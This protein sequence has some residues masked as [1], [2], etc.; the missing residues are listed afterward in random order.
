VSTHDELE[1]ILEAAAWRDLAP[2]L[3][4]DPTGG[5]GT[6]VRQ[7]YRSRRAHWTRAHR[8]SGVPKDPDENPSACL[9]ALAV[10]LATPEQAASRLGTLTWGWQG[11]P[12]DAFLV[13]LAAARGREW[14]VPFLEAAS[15]AKVAK[16]DEY[17][18]GWIARLTLPLV[19]AGVADLPTGPAFG[20]S[21]A[22]HYAGGGA[23]AKWAAYRERHAELYRNAPEPPVPDE[24]LVD[25]LRADPALAEGVA[26]ALA[27]PGA[28]GRLEAS[29]APGWELGPALA[30]LV[31][32]G[33]LDR[34]RVVDD[35]LAALTRQDPAGT[36]RGLGKLLT[37]LGLR[38]DDLAGRMPL[39]LGLMAT[40]RGPVTAA[41]LPPAL[42]TAGPE[43][44]GELAATVL[45][46]PEK[47]QRARLLKAL[48]ARGA[49]ARWGRDAVVGSLELAVQVPD[50]A[51]ASRA[52]TALAGLGVAHVEVEEVPPSEL[53]GPAPEV[54]EAGPVTEIDPTEP[55]LTAALSRLM[56]GSDASDAAVFWDAAVRWCA[57]STRD[58][59]AWADATMS[60]PDVV[61]LPSA[62]QAIADR[63]RATPE[64][65]AVLCQDIVRLR[66]DGV[67]RHGPDIDWG[68]SSLSTTSCIHQV[69]ASETTLRLGD[70]PFLV[71]TPTRWNGGLDLASL[72]GRLRAYGSTPVGPA[73]LFLALLRLEEVPPERA[74]E[75]DGTRVP[76][77]S[78]GRSARWPLRRRQTGP[79]D[80]ADLVRRWV[81]GGGLPHLPVRHHGGTVTIEPVRLPVALD[82]FPGMP[83]EL[84]NG[85]VSGVQDEYY[86]WE[87]TAETGL[88]VAPAWADLLAAR[89][90]TQFDQAARFPPRWLPMMAHAPAPGR[91]VLH[92]LAAT[93]C[94]ADEDHRLLAVESALI[95]MGRR[96]WDPVAYTECCEHMLADG[97][98]RLGR[99]THAWEQLI[100]AGGLQV[101][102]PTA[103]AVIAA[104]S[105]SDRKPPG[106]ADLLGMLRRYVGAVP[107][108]DVP[109]GVLALARSRGTTKAKAAATAF[110]SATA[111]SC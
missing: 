33:R 4:A 70:I 34:A 79:A 23:R 94:H 97:V 30:E 55:G 14:C 46:R 11:D 108:P 99:L 17:L 6:E 104:A 73:D 1:R 42:E 27:T 35:A 22:A 16:D 82:S 63:R 62:V 93:L 74:G 45:A 3:S 12:S 9:R 8:W 101:L 40:S 64:R 111:R 44:L 54:A 103:R 52:A 109:P 43:H 19:A 15:S 68:I 51:F 86:D 26:V 32:E 38:G 5:T 77:W 106:L 98:L 69:F 65:H 88:G 67:R 50:E 90:Q 2:L 56:T 96:L 20:L 80:A 18:I 87:V 41:L 92:V 49:V 75:L 58:A 85:H 29:A 78:P 48:T 36:Q 37:A 57:H 76:L 7:W 110:V 66:T 53:W 71:S 21:W 60:G 95:L 72:V 81:E 31:A 25:L 59:V 28:V 107:E 105:E 47:A 91:A 10:A 102:W 13:E 89:T 100:L 39:V 24:R 83:P 84:V 61:R